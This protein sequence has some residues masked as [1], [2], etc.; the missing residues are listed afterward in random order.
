MVYSGDGS[1]WTQYPP[2]NDSAS[3]RCR[4]VFF[5]LKGNTLPYEIY[6]RG[7]R[8]EVVNTDTGETHSKHT[9]KTKAQAQVDLL[10]SKENPGEP[11]RVTYLSNGT[12]V[13]IHYKGKQNG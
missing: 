7:T 4:G 11:D 10:E 8:F 6:K 12:K 9:T 13:N 2:D 1:R 5:S 3:G